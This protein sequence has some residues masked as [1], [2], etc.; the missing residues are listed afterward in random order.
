MEI[1]SSSLALP[2]F[3]ELVQKALLKERA[4]IFLLA[5]GK[6]VSTLRSKLRFHNPTR[7]L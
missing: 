7:D 4:F 1:Q 2:K 6:G 3:A 5:G